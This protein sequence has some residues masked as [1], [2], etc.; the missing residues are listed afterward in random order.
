MTGGGQEWVGSGVMAVEVPF[1]RMRLNWTG[2]AGWG[3]S[4]RTQ[5]D[6]RGTTLLAKAGLNDG[7][8]GRFA[9]AYTPA[10]AGR[11]APWLVD[12][13]STTC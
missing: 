1:S 9:R 6:G 7:G 8:G 13:A 3:L 2:A 10:P 12:R 4:E 11:L 5:P